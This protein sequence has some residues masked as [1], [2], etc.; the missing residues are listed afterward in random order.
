MYPSSSTFPS[1]KIKVIGWHLIV[2]AKNQRSPASAPIRKAI[3]A[4]GS[5]CTGVQKQYTNVHT[6]RC[7]QNFHRWESNWNEANNNNRIF[8][9]DPQEPK[10]EPG[11]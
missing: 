1:I 7:S 8:A 10:Q 5:S 2:D 11:S 3:L 4:S 9:F 6:T